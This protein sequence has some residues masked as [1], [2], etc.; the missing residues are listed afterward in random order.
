MTSTLPHHENECE[1]SVNNCRLCILGNQGIAWILEL[2]TEL[3]TAWIGKNQKYKRKNMDS[4]IINITNCKT[5]KRS[6]LD[7]E[8]VILI[9][10]YYQTAK[11]R[12]L[13]IST[14]GPAEWSAANLP[15]SDWLGDFC[16]TIPELTVRVYWRHRPQNWNGLVLTRIRIRSECPET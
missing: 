3:L 9:R 14:D 11:T 12:A 16:C 8:F 1:R 13:Y 7:V 6:L 4:K 10:Y 2:I 5:C 15:N